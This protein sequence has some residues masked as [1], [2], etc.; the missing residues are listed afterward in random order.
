M[1]EG[2]MSEGSMSDS[3]G[4][5]KSIA[6]FTDLVHAGVAQTINPISKHTYRD[7][8]DQIEIDGAAKPLAFQFEK[9][10]LKCSPSSCRDL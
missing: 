7:A 3:V 6:S 1:P 9:R 4:E 10:G 8:L 2:S 5:R